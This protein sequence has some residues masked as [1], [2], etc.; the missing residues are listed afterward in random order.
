[1]SSSL[2]KVFARRSGLTGLVSAVSTLSNVMDTLTVVAIIESMDYCRKLNRL[3]KKRHI[4]MDKDFM[5]NVMK[6]RSERIWRRSEDYD[7]L[8]AME[9]FGY[10]TNAI[11]LGFSEEEA[12]EI[13][14]NIYMK[15]CEEE[16]Y[17]E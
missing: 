7:D 2:R 12:N 1:M 10:Y 6:N 14:F 15:E 17:D 13:V 16:E 11:E 4:F 8:L 5:E 3:L 9:S